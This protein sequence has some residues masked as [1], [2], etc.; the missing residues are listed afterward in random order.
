MSD[1]PAGQVGPGW[2]QRAGVREILAGW[3]IAALYRVL[4]DEGGLSQR[5]IAARTGQQQSEVAEILS[6]RQVENHRLL[7]RIAAGLDVTPEM[8]GLSWWGPEGTYHGPQ[9]GYPDGGGGT[10][11]RSPEGVRADMLRRHL[12]ALGMVVLTGQPLRYRELREL[13]GAT[14]GPVPLPS[15]ICGVH[16][17]KVH[18]LRQ[19]LTRLSRAHG[20]DPEMSGAAVRWAR[21]L[22][23]VPS[24]EP[25]TQALRVAVAELEIQAGFA[26]FD[27]GPYAHAT[28]HWTRAL[29]LATH[30]GDTYL[31]ALAL[32]Y[33]GLATVEH[34]H[35]SDGLKLLQCAQAK[36]WDIPPGDERAVARSTRAAVEA[37]IL[38]DSALA[39]ERLG[40]QA[41]ADQALSES[42]QLWTPS[43]T[44]TNGDLDAVGTQ[45]QLARGQLD[46]AQ[47][48][49]TASVRR[50]EN[51]TNQRASTMTGILL[52][53]VHVRAGEHDG[54]QLA[55]MTRQ[56]IT[57][58]I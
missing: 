53:T 3:D 57:T 50:W 43:H 52:A 26:G 13:P 44:D 7:R 24:A 27:A 39:L 15:R 48:S 22:L 41:A 40:D 2:Y 19:Q 6:G 55:R 47:Q 9:G 12:V 10:V 5:Q 54:L 56:I 25:V 45:L 37:C 8:M 17:A 11:D 4:Q 21:R 14:P 28:H 1:D 29:Q 35:P 49:A 33:A 16:V 58:R 30:A 42:H 51:V 32:A 36:A 34:G 46:T 18:D 23:G 38:A 31:Q 20:S